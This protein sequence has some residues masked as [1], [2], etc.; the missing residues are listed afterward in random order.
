MCCDIELEAQRSCGHCRQLN[1][2]VRVLRYFLHVQTRNSKQHTPRSLLNK[3]KNKKM[4]LKLPERIRN[5]VNENGM[6][7][8]N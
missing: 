3:E 5:E 6:K 2:A 1:C 8:R 7:E 4:I